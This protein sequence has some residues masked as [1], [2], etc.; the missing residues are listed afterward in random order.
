MLSE[1]I[2]VITVPAGI[3]VPVTPSPIA[4]PTFAAFASKVIVLQAFAIDENC[5]VV[6]AGIAA[7]TAEDKFIVTAPEMK[8]IVTLV[9]VVPEAIPDPVTYIPAENI[10]A[11]DT[12]FAIKIEVAPLVTAVAP[13]VPENVPVAP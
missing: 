10:L 1:A 2:A 7:V 5:N 12:L 3:P 13:T 4:N 11:R 6:A 8:L 9:I